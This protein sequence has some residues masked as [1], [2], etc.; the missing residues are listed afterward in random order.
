[1]ALPEG[2]TT[3]AVE[4][5][6]QRSYDNAR[7]SNP[8]LPLAPWDA[9][10]PMQKHSGLEVSAHFLAPLWPLIEKHVDD[11]ITLHAGVLRARIEMFIDELRGRGLGEGVN[12]AGELEQ[13]INT[14][15]ED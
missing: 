12:I 10:S 7:Q 13:I 14:P 8:E 9:L 3:A 15:M 11:E 6:A 2:L 1:M 4:A 5:V